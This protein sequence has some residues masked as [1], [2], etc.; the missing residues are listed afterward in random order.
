MR[1]VPRA[2]RGPADGERRVRERQRAEKRQEGI[3]LRGE[4]AVWV[5]PLRLAR[6][7]DRARARLARGDDEIVDAAPRDRDGRGERAVT[8]VR[9]EDHVVRDD[10]LAVGAVV[11]GGGSRRSSR[12]RRLGRGGRRVGRDDEPARRRGAAPR[13]GG[14]R[15]Q[16]ARRRPLGAAARRGRAGGHLAV[17]SND[18]GRA[19]VGAVAR[20][21]V[22]AQP[23]ELRRVEEEDLHHTRVPRIGAHKV[24][25]HGDRRG[26]GRRRR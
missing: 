2:Q 16:R 1:P 24:E 18:R 5:A 22:G 13:Y 6:E 12:R 15:R 9:R 10:L 3:E 8:L 11:V 26:G 23:M 19:A 20:A 7:A 21:D 14:A 17:G 25:V 4:E